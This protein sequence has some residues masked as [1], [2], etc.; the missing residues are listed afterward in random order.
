MERATVQLPRFPTSQKNTAA[1]A[2][3]ELFPLRHHTFFSFIIHGCKTQ[4][5][6]RAATTLMEKRMT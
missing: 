3:A 5:N 2:K 4:A 6:P 1:S